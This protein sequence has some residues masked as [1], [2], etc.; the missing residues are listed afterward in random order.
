MNQ[1][2]KTPPGAGG[3]FILYITPLLVWQS[4]QRPCQ[5]RC[6]RELYSL[7]T[8]GSQTLTLRYGRFAICHN[9]ECLAPIG[10]QMQ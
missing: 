3:V 2:A 6:D 5:G 10:A 9:G 1:I 4:Q 7:D 8:L